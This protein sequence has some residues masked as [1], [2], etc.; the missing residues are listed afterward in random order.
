MEINSSSLYHCNSKIKFI[1]D[2]PSLSTTKLC[3]AHFVDLADHIL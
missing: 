1:T 2:K 3:L